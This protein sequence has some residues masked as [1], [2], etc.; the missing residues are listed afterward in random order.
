LRAQQPEEQAAA[1]TKLRAALAAVSAALVRRGGP[2]LLGPAP[3]IGDFLLWPFIER[4]CVLEHYRGFTVPPELGPFAAW[5]AAMGALPAVQKTRQ[6]P[7]F[8]VAGYAKYANP[9]AP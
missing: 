1:A 5:V 2:F 9:A 3:T 4:L 7:A 8:F 6:P